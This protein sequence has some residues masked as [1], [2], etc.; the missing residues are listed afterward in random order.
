MFESFALND[1]SI[2]GNKFST[3]FAISWSTNK[4]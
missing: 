4:T 2:I 3:S 1:E